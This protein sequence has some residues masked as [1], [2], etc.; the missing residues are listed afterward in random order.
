MP[1]LSTADFP[2]EGYALHVDVVLG[3]SGPPKDAVLA[4]ERGVVTELSEAAIYKA[5]PSRPRAIRLAGTAILPGILDV[6]HHIIEPFV[7]A[8]TGGEPAQMWWRIWLPLEATLT[9]HGA[10]I[11]AVWTFLEA[12]RGGITTIVDHGIRTRAIADAIHRAATDTGIRLVSSIG[13]Y[14]LKNFSTGARM[15]ALVQDV[16]AALRIA[17]QHVA[18]CEPFPR[19]CLRSPAAPCSRTPAT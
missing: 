7:K 19:I 15:P 8:L 2:A 14:D 12:L 4:V 6:H 13:V 1:T 3:P 9:E 11:G 17:E 10:Y 18:D 5:Q 16:D